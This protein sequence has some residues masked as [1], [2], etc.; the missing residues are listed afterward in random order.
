MSEVL[1]I[2]LQEHDRVFNEFK[3]VC[4]IADLETI[5]THTEQTKSRVN[6]FVIFVAVVA[7]LASCGVTYSTGIIKPVKEIAK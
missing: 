1:A 2:K 3:R 5:E 4:G 6:Y 7:L